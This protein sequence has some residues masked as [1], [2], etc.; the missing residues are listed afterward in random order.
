MLG[1]KY[2]HLRWSSTG[3][4]DFILDLYEERNARAPIG[5]EEWVATE[6]DS[7]RTQSQYEAKY[8]PKF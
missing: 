5:F 4:L 1:I 6:Y 2:L 8:S 3:I 7:T